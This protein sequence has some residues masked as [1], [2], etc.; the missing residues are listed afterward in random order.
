MSNP[1][2]SSIERQ[3]ARSDLST[4]K[5]RLESYLSANPKEHDLRLLLLLVGPA[6]IIG[7]V[8][9]SFMF[10]SLMI[11]SALTFLLAAA[12]YGYLGYQ[13]YLK[14]RWKND[15]ISQAD[16]NRCRDFSGFLKNLITESMEHAGGTLTYSQLEV[17]AK[18]ADE[19]L[20]KEEVRAIVARQLSSKAETN[21][22][23][24]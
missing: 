21:H 11:G 9:Y 2:L 23:S 15:Q 8:G 1:V 7:A 18:N 5:I 22:F 4:L 20:K 12:A 14:P 17:I 10:F 6:V 13:G 24:R 16:F 3:Q 19:L